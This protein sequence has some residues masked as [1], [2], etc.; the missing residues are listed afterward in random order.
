MQSVAHGADFISFFRWRTCTFGTEMY[1]HGILDYDNRD[2]RKLAEVRDFYQKLKQLDP[3]CGSKYTAAFGVL[4]DYD[5]VWD[6]NVDVWHKRV[7]E[8]SDEAIFAASQINHTPYDFVYLDVTTSLEELLAY[9]VLF[10]PHP[11]IM[12]AEKAALLERYVEAGGT[13]IIG[14]R[15]GYKQENGKCVMMAQPGLLQKLTGSDVRDFTFAS[16]AEDPVYAKWDGR[17]MDLPLFHDILETTGDDVKVLATYQGSYYSGKAALTEK[18][19]GKGRTLH[20]GSVF[21]RENVKRLLEYTGILE[22]FGNMIHAPETVEVIQRCQGEKIY[23][24]LLNYQSDEQKVEIRKPARRLF[25]GSEVC[26]ELVLPAYGVE[27][28]QM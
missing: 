23:Y 4:K 9:P 25:S 2:N 19:T 1:W 8:A 7:H 13:L 3:V 26:G 10:Y 12:T 28:L 5:N 24:F 22:P 27:V 17:K 6:T 20:L 15:S 14:C 11:V 18:R 16:K 21:S